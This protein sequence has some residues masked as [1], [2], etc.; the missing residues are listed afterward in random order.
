MCGG[1]LFE[2]MNLSKNPDA[3][4]RQHEPVSDS[5]RKAVRSSEQFRVMPLQTQCR[6]NSSHRGASYGNSN[7]KV[8]FKDYIKT[9]N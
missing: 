9:S 2:N 3:V 8:K 7:F 1:K 5:A 4:K 6:K